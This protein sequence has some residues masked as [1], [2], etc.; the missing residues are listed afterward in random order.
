[1]F[2]SLLLCSF[3]RF[4]WIHSESDRNGTQRQQFYLYVDGTCNH[5][6]LCVEF[7]LSVALRCCLYF[8]TP[9]CTRTLLSVVILH[10]HFIRK[11]IS[12]VKYLY[13]RNHLNY[14]MFASIMA[15]LMKSQIILVSAWTFGAEKT[16]TVRGGG[17]YLEFEHDLVWYVFKRNW[18]FLCVALFTKN[19]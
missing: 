11:S 2:Q 9:E 1:M 16:F 18:W 4:H 3:W 8:G 6:W 7:S 15:F 17:R 10:V 13:T 5:V 12:D 14:L 19:R